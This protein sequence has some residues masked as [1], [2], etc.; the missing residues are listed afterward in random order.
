MSLTDPIADLLTRIRNGQNA[1]KE[2]VAMPSSKAEDIG[3]RG[4]KTGGIHR[5]YQSD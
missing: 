2:L 1:H 5:R 4:A 3:L